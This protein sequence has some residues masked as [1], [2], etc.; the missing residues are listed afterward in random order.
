MSHCTCDLLDVVWLIR[1]CHWNTSNTGQIDQSEVWACV[2]IDGQHNWLVDD[3]LAL[4]TH[5]VSQEVDCLLYFLEIS[6]FPVR[7]FIKLAPWLCAWGVVESQ[8]EGPSSDHTVSSWEEV[9]THD[10]LEH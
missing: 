10:G 6:E 5:L 1:A 3:V 8:F 7:H 2:R 9:E 4:S